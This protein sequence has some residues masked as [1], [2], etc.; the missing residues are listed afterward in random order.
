MIASA[1]SYSAR[2]R[3]YGAK[4]GRVMKLAAAC[5]QAGYRY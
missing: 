5:R 1:Y 2:L 4:D 3:Q